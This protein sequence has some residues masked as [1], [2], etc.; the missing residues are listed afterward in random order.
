MRNNWFRRNFERFARWIEGEDPEE[1]KKSYHIVPDRIKSTKELR[2]E[3]LTNN[4]TAKGHYQNK[5]LRKRFLEW[6]SS[7]G[8]VFFYH[9]YRVMAVLICFTMIFLLLLVTSHLPAFGDAS[10]P[11][12]NEVFV[13]YIKDTLADT[14][15]TN[16]VAGVIL[17]YRAFDTFG[18]ASVLFIAACAVTILLRQTGSDK[19]QKVS[20]PLKHDLILTKAATLIVPIV[21]LYG[22]Y[23]ILNGHISPGGG[24]SGGTLI[25]AGLILYLCAFGAGQ[26]A[27]FVNYR[28]YLYV[29]LAAL[30]YYALAKGYSFFT[31]ANHLDSAIPHGEPGAILSGGLILSLNIAV[32]VVVACTM[33]GFYSLFS[34]EDI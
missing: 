16:V 11:A 5:G 25:G 2:E 15:A 12:H 3:H 10:N 17:D 18:E 26:I 23:V 14:N 7:N 34:R 19:K 31:G 24:F 28:R 33:Y 30:G 6:Q 8:S 13:K 21:M 32:G 1:D 29:N 27:R 4:E 9:L 22:V 20:I